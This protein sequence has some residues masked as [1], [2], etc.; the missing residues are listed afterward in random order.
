MVVYRYSKK[1]NNIN[2]GNKN[3]TGIQFR[4]YFYQ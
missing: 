4:K 1:P 2:G 3:E